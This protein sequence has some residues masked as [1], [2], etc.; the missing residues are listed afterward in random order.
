M[1]TPRSS[2]KDVSVPLSEETINVLRDFGYQIEPHPWEFGDLQL[3]ENTTGEW[4]AAS[5]PRGIGV[6]KVINDMN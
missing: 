5:D 1:T 3:I 2:L 6:A 4:R